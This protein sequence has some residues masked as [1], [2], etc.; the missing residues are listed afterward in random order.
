MFAGHKTRREIRVLRLMIAES[1]SN[2]LEED[3]SARRIQGAV[4]GWWART[5]TRLSKT[6]VLRTSTRL[7]KTHVLTRLCKTHVKAH[8][9]KN[10]NLRLQDELKS[11]S[12]RASAAAAECAAEA[13]RLLQGNTVQGRWDFMM[14]E[15]DANLAEEDES[16]SCIQ[17]V[18]AGWKVRKVV[19]SWNAMVAESDQNLL[20]EDESARRLQ[21]ALIGW[22]ARR[23]NHECIE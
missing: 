9:L 15:S 22:S 14:K 2:L 17:A 21:A 18:M 11:L 12:D 16:A 1:D 8:A 6:H 19:R 13:K 7:S 5:S 10:K 3:E 4:A 23:V 20:E